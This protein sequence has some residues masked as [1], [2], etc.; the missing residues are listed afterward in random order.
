MAGR[1][2]HDRITTQNLT[3]H[4]VDAER[5]L[6]L[7]KG[8]VP[9]PARRARVRQEAAKGGDGMTTRVK[10]PTARPADGRAP[11]ARLRRPGQHRADAPGRRRP[12]WPRPARARTPPRPAARSAAVARSRTAR[13]APAAPVRARPAPRSSPAVASSHGPTPRD[14]TPAHPEEDEGRRPARRAL[15][16]GPRRAACYVVD[17]LVAGRDARPRSRRAPRSPTCGRRAKVL[18]VARP[19]RRAR[20][21]CRC[22]TCRTCT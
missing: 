14:Y 4:R 9:G 16:P 18:V 8:A 10:T 12:S 19:R 6:L 1:M 17:S 13:R 5:G 21:G 20:P 3:V 2:G 15:R 22:A 7:I 11:R